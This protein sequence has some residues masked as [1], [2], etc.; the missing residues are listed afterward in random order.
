M[1]IKNPLWLRGFLFFFVH[2]IEIKI[3]NLMNMNTAVNINS[4]TSNKAR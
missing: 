1:K 3:L 4:S 2:Q